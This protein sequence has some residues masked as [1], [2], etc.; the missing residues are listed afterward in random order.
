MK[1][2]R[3]KE[4]MGDSIFEKDIADVAIELPYLRPSS[5]IFLTNS[6]FS[7]TSRNHDRLNLAS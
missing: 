1:K 5:V 7:F 4:G 2:R 3:R 6:L